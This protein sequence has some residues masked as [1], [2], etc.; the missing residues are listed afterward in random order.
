M[1]V[2]FLLPIWRN[3][4]Q[5]DFWP[6][7]LV[8]LAHRWLR[9]AINGDFLLLTQHGLIN[10]TEVPSMPVASIAILHG[11]RIALLEGGKLIRGQGECHL[12]GRAII[13][14]AADVELLARNLKDEE[15]PSG[16]KGSIA[17]L[18]VD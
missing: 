12:V 6:A 18:A 13:A 5:A 4:L 7:R 16:K 1:G 11:D 10:M 15:F 8:S 2:A 9:Q 17:G 14:Q 3:F